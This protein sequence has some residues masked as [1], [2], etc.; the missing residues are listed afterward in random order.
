MVD[1]QHPHLNNSYY[2]N[3]IVVKFAVWKININFVHN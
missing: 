3:Y 1:S 2:N